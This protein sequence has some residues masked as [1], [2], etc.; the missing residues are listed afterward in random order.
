MVHSIKSS[1]LKLD[2]FGP[3]SSTMYPPLPQ[4]IGGCGRWRDGGSLEWKAGKAA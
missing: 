2:V 4:H 1:E 3:F